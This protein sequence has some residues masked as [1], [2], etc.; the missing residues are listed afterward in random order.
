MLDSLCDVLRAS[1][2]KGWISTRDGNGSVR[3]TS[4]DYFHVTPS[5]QKKFK[6]DA[7]D[8]LKI[9]WD[10]KY[11]GS[12][13]VSPDVSINNGL[14]LYENKGHKPTGEYLLHAYLQREITHNRVV[15]HL[16][17]T[18]IIAAIYAG[19]DLTQVSKDFP[20]INRYTRVGP[21]VPMIEPISK[22]LALATIDALNL[23]PNGDIDYDIVG[24]DRHGVVS[25]A[26]DPWT[27]FEHVERLEHICQIVLASKRY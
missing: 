18:Y 9:E 22:A 14:A 17:P 27:A 24:L 2:E 15:L 12:E 21:T 19:I 10:K 3:Y 13:N 25:V 26:Q 11:V 16:H 5:G 7:E 4:R 20:E 6:L 1:Y 8:F 23:Q